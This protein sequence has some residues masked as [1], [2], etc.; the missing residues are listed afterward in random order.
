M[1]LETAR[2]SCIPTYAISILARTSHLSTSQASPSER[3]VAELLTTEC[4][5][6]ATTNKRTTRVQFVDLP[7]QIADISQ[8]GL[9]R[10]IQAMIIT[11]SSTSSR[12]AD[13]QTLSGG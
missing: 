5:A 13:N 7:R 1:S 12:L 11:N 10:N 6:Y 2:S 9:Q 4:S 8:K 3:Y